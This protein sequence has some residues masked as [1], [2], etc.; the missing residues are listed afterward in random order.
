MSMMWRLPAR[1]PIIARICERARRQVTP[2]ARL[3]AA[4]EALVAID[5]DRRPA[6]RVLNAFLRGRRYIGAKDRHAISGRVYAVLRQR[7][8]LDWMITQKAAAIPLDARGRVLASVALEGDTAVLAQIGTDR[9]GPPALSHL[10]AD[11]VA[12][13]AAAPPAMTAAPAHVRLEAPAWMVACLEEDLGAGAAPLLAAMTESAAMD[14]RINPA[15]AD[16][17]ALR[18]VLADQGMTAEPTPLSPY[19]LRVRERR[20]IDGLPAFKDGHFEVQDEGSQVAAAL[21][22]ARPG[23]QIC[24]FCAGAGGKSLAMAANMGNRGRILALD[25]S[26]ARLKRLG[27]RLKR[28]G[29]DNIEPRHIAHERD[30]SLK[31]AKGKFDRVLVDAPCSGTGTWRRNPDARWRYGP[32]EVAEICEL[33]NAILAAAARLVKPGGRLVYVTCSVLRTENEDVVAA[34]QAGHADFALMP[35]PAVWTETLGAEGVPCP[36]SGPVLHLRPDRHGTDGFF[37]AVLERREVGTL[38]N[39]EAAG[40]G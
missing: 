36:V 37:V 10:E 27:Q 39:A 5:G 2:A 25:T 38:A 15:R 24:D 19:G 18:A 16:R 21:V 34:F 35:M 8:R 28:A 1:R 12:A 4:I 17:A 9:H 33:Q 13:L 3:A 7:T 32:D 26:A 14:L 22:G 23:M 11:M 6:D 20:P 31:R 40:D 30:R 29:H